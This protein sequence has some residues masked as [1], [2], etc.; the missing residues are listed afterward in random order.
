MPHSTRALSSR[1][2]VA[3][4][5]HPHGA[6][7]LAVALA[8]VLLALTPAG[9]GETAAITPRAPL[10]LFNG[11]DLAAF[12]TWLASSGTADPDRVFSVVNGIDG[13]PAIRFS[14]QHY[15]GILTRERYT[16]YRFVM[17]F[18]WGLLTWEPR[19]KAA[20]D[21]GVLFHCQGE[22]GNNTPDF[23]APWQR[24]IECQ[25]IEGGTGDLIIVGGYERGRP[26][27]LFPTLQST[28]TPGTRRWNPQG[29]PG[30]FG[31][32]RNRTDAGYKD[33]AWKDVTGFRGAHDAEK[34]VGQWNHLEVVCAGRS[35]AYF[36]NGV[37]VN[38]A[39]DASLS[40][41]RLLIQSEGAELF[42]RKIE[43][44]P[45]QK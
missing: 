21:S 22:P 7:T 30:Q 44:H 38:A 6:I 33:P 8:F 12:T 43:L 1:P 2:P 42:V 24:S 13:A 5:T 45:L 39:T 32:G 14:G 19:K 20:R 9:R 26:E 29:E 27:M 28:V 40:E 25:L 17:E 11:Q 41:G 16:N 31:K 34:P 36:L 10:S 23:R 3:P 4:A 35:L 37:P 18:R 15:G